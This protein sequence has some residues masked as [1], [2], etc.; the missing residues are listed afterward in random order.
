VAMLGFLF[1][2]TNIGFFVIIGAMMVSELLICMWL[3]TLYSERTF[4]LK[5]MVEF[6]TRKAIL[7]VLPLIG[8][9]VD[10]TW[11]LAAP[12][13]LEAPIS[14]PYL[15]T[16][17]MLIGV[18]AY[19]LKRVL[20]GVLVVYKDIPVAQRLMHQLD[21]M[22]HGGEPPPANRRVYDPP[23]ENDPIQREEDEK[24]LDR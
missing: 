16:R 21:K 20:E 7:L 1:G 4:E 9:A 22:M 18:V 10:W 13:G 24:D 2:N 19:Q 8:S 14:I 3:A 11:Y 5:E 6:W 12:P 17:V 15:T 23:F